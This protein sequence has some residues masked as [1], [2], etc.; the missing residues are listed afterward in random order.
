MTVFTNG[1]D[2]ERYIRVLQET[3]VLMAEDIHKCGAPISPY[4][5]VEDVI[6]SYMKQA[7]GPSVLESLLIEQGDISLEDVQRNSYMYYTVESLKR[8]AEEVSIKQLNK[9]AKWITF[10][11]N[12]KEIAAI[13]IKGS[14]PG[15]VKETVALLAYEKKVDPSEIVVGAR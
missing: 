10:S 9:K 13:S 6:D 14:F 5:K 2:L 8:I 3:V 11:L 12:G 7:S 4:M 1:R 15:E